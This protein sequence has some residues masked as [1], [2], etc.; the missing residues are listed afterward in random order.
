MDI[1]LL[2]IILIFLL[3]IADYKH[4][5]HKKHIRKQNIIYLDCFITSCYWNFNILFNS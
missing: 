2:L 3:D 5:T 1:S 4:C